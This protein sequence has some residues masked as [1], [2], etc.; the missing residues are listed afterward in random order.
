VFSVL[1]RIHPIMTS[2]GQRRGAQS[3]TISH[4]DH[5]RIL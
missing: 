2:G 1:R 4:I 3:N 5:L